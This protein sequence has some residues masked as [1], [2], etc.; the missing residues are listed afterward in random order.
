MHLELPF[1]PP[2]VVKSAPADQ[3][4]AILPPLPASGPGGSSSTPIAVVTFGPIRVMPDEPRAWQDEITRGDLPRGCRAQLGRTLD[5]ATETGW[6]MR[7]VECEVV[8]GPEGAVELVESRLCAFY[9]FL[10]HS[11]AAV[12]RTGTRASLEE[13]GPSIL[14]ILQGGRPAWRTGPAC[15]ADLWDLE[16]ATAPVTTLPRLAPIGRPLRDPAALQRD[17]DATDTA[18]VAAGAT[19]DV[20]AQLRRAGML[21]ELGR[22]A[23]AIRAF[24]AVLAIDDSLELAHYVRGVALLALGRT[25]D[26]I[27]AWRRA[28]ALGPERV[29]THYNLALALYENEEPAAA[30]PEFETVARLDP[31]DFM[32]GRKVAQCL[33]ALGRF[34]D[35]ERARAAFR[36][37]WSTTRDPRARFITEFVFDQF[38]ADGFSVHAIETLRPARPSKFTVL[39]FHAVERHWHHEHPLP[40]AVLVETSD[41]A[42]AAGTPFVIGLRTGKPPSSRFQVIGSAVTLPAYPA[43]KAEVTRVLREALALRAPA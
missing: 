41:V 40:A 34:D 16:A 36:Q 12:V 19:P 1:S 25:A 5:L 8:T 13:H 18:S 32:V 26:A 37:R 20:D 43:L 31:E 4:A 29:E 17:L 23:E 24:D 39:A 33:Y 22:H 15:V 30:L 21:Q 2:W 10:E 35:G 14:A 28:A 11:A 3:F 7:L 38:D 9:S 27:V 42:I 6:P